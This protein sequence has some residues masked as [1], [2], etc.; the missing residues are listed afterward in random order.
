MVAIAGRQTKEDKRELADTVARAVAAAVE[1]EG[2]ALSVTCD[3]PAREL[4]PDGS[5]WKKYEPGP[6]TCITIH[7]RPQ[8]RGAK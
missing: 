2:K 3:R 1:D 4:P 8:A 6:D 7:I 5:G